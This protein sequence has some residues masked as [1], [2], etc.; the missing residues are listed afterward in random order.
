MI[1]LVLVRQANIL[2]ADPMLK[3]DLQRILTLLTA[4]SLSIA[5][6]SSSSI[7]RTKALMPQS[8]IIVAKNALTMLN[9]L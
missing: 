1:V 2:R 3:Q 5:S 8:A 6:T 9:K 4:T 7:P